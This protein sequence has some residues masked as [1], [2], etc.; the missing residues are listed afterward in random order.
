MSESSKWFYVS[1]FPSETIRDLIQSIRSGTMVTDM[2]RTGKDIQTVLQW[3]ANVTLG[4]PDIRPEMRGEPPE[5]TAEQ[6]AA[7]V[8]LEHALGGVQDSAVTMQG[9]ISRRV[10][11]VVLRRVFAL[12][13]GLLLEWAE[14][15]ALTEGNH[16]D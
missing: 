4:D 6:I 14:K 2:P 1:E 12:L 8:E 9:P 13:I 7:C 10:A 15:Y 5:I 11:E 16:D 3:I